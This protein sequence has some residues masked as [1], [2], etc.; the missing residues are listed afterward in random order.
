M[1][2]VILHSNVLLV[3]LGLR[4]RLRLIWDAFVNGIFELIVSEEIVREYEEM[5]HQ[6]SAPGVA[7]LVMNMLEES[8]NVIYQ[9]VSYNWKAVAADPD[10][11][12]IKKKRVVPGTPNLPIST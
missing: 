10:D 4:R 12:N 1:L 8:T 2:E 3:S 7:A 11:D 6:H 9:R 5:L